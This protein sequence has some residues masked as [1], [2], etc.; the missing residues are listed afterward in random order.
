MSQMEK[1]ELL[2]IA[3]GM[4]T[5]EQQIFVMGIPSEILET[6]LERRYEVALKKLNGVE[7]A[8]NKL[9]DERDLT[10]AKAVEIINDIRRVI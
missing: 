3:M 9:R 10:L 4:E 6:E 7:T 5:S 2:D 8:I 1:N